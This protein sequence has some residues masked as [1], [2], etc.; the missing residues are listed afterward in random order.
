[1]LYDNISVLFQII[2]PILF[3]IIFGNILHFYFNKNIKYHGPNSS[4]IR[5]TI[6]V[7]KK[8]KKCYIFEPNIYM[9]P[10]F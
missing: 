7:N 3:G 4:I 6:F 1:M 10:I 8:S 9:C 2:F 5:K